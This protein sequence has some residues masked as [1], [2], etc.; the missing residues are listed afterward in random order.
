MFLLMSGAEGSCKQQVAKAFE[1]DGYT[2]LS[3]DAVLPSDEFEI[4]Q[5]RIDLHREA[6]KLSKRKNIV[7][8]RSPYESVYVYGRLKLQ[9]NQLSKKDYERLED[10]LNHADLQPPD[11]MVYL[12]HSAKMSAF[13][14]M[15]LCNQDPVEEDYDDIC[16]LYNEI[17]DRVKI[18]L[19]KCDVSQNFDTVL[20]DLDFSIAAVRSIRLDMSSIY[21]KEMFYGI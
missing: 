18:P 17:V 20:K 2:T 5:K 1:K 12:Y 13:N 15:L 9:N 11:M 7:M 4:L 8:I 21:K 10:Q 6:E 19:V 3:L 14:R 16:S